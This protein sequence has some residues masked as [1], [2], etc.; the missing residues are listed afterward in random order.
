[1]SSCTSCGHESAS[2]ARFCAECGLP[3]V[4]PAAAGA[5]VIGNSGKDKSHWLTA[6]DT[7]ESAA[8]R[9]PV[10]KRGAKHPLA[11]VGAALLLAVLAWNL[12]RAPTT[13]V[14][15]LAGDLAPA[16]PST[17]AT[18]DAAE[19]GS[20]SATATTTGVE[21]ETDITELDPNLTGYDL[22]ASRPG[23]L[24]RIDLSDGAVTEYQLTAELIGAFESRLLFLESN[25]DISARPL[26][27]PDAEPD[28]IMAR[29][30][31]GDEL[32]AVAVTTDGLLHVTLVNFSD[33]SPSF[34]MVRI[35]LRSGA[36]H[37]ENVSQFGTFGLVEVPGA[38]LFELT[39]N[40]FR[41]LADGS[42]RFGGE[43]LIVVEECDAPDACR[44]YWLDRVTGDQVD[45]PLP[46]AESG[47]LM[48]PDGRIAVIFDPTGSV[49]LD[50]ESGESVPEGVTFRGDRFGPILPDYWVHDDRFLI[51]AEAEG[52]RDILIHDLDRDTSSAIELVGTSS[53][54]K[55]LLV[56]RPDGEQ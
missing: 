35:N 20:A 14:E 33:L 56:P 23:L 21:I 13:K 50:T 10:T 5:E 19:G 53:L 15:G 27:D 26:D 46:E 1:M 42:V 47:L 55:V 51:A 31:A 43:R 45:R 12:F 40:G 28:I 6:P 38:G 32:I 3:L 37:R 11:A 18:T 39:E 2:T 24:T 29:D 54:S 25:G 8:V 41:S 44:R 9:R 17:T 36:V 34:S 48:G 4:S 7:A 30:D 49:F 22:F 52:G 16:G